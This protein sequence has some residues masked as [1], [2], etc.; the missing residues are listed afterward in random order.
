MARHRYKKQ[1][2]INNNCRN[3][4]DSLNSND[5]FGK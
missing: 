1:P 3:K 4:R 5:N 2:A